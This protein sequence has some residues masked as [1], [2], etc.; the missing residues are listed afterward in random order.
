[1]AFVRKS[2]KPN[3]EYWPKAASVEI[4]VGALTYMISGY[5]NPADATSGDHLGICMKKIASTDADYASTTKIPIDVPG[6]NDVF[7][8]DLD[9]ATALATLAALVGT[10]I[11]I[12]TSLLADPDASSKDVLLIVGV[13]STSKILVKIAS[14]INILRTATT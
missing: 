5:V 7:E 2:G 12:S 14:R 3:I 4:G 8:V 6:E 1:M 13:V 9:T 11:D 10:Y